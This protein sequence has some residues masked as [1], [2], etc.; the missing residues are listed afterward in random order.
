MIELR[1][2]YSAPLLSAEEGLQS[3]ALVPVLPP[4][5][6]LKAHRHSVGC[7]VGGGY[8]SMALAPTMMVKRGSGDL[9]MHVIGLLVKQ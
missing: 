3:L 4:R 1:L 9:A 7:R 5:L 6:V 8:A 2:C